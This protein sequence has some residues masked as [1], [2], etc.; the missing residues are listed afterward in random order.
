MKY[1]LIMSAVYYAC[2]CFYM[3]FGPYAIVSNIKSSTNRLFMLLTSSMA[4]WAFTYSIS[5]SAM[6]A[7]SSAF[8]RCLSVFGWGIFHN[9]LLHFALILTNNKHQV[10]NFKNFIIV[11][12]PTFINIFL[13]AP[14][15]YL[16]ENQYEM[17]PSDFGW[18]NSLPANIGQIWINFYYIVYTVAA[19]ILIIRWWKKLDP[20]NPMK[21]QVQYFLIAIMLPLVVGTIN[22]I[23][24]GALGLYQTPRITLILLIFPTI[25]LFQTLKKFGFIIEKP[26]ATYSPMGST[27]ALEKGR[28]R[29]FQ[30]AAVIFMA[31]G[32][33]SF[34][35]GYFTAS[36]SLANELPLALTVIVIGAFLIFIPYISAKDN[37]Q[38]TL[39]L[40]VSIV[41]MSFFIIRDADIGGVTIWAVYVVFLLYTIILNSRIH[42]LLFLGITLISQVI[43]WITHPKAYTV[44][45]DT[46]YLKRIVIVVLSYVLVRYLTTEYDSKLKGYQRFAKEHEVLEK[47][48]SSFI[49]VDNENIKAKI[50]GMLK[51]T[52]EIL[53]IDQIYLVELGWD[54]EY[55]MIIDAYTADGSTKSLPFPPGVKVEAAA[56]P[57]VE[58]MIEHKQPISCE[59]I[60][61]VFVDE[62]GDEGKFFTSRGINSYYMLP[63]ELDENII[64]VLVVEQ[65][66]KIDEKLR[67]SQAYFLSLIANI[68]GD[69]KRKILDEEKLYNF[70]YFDEDT[71]LANK[72]RL[73][74]VLDQ[75][76]YSR[77]DSGKLAVLSIEIDNLR[78]IKDTFGHSIGEQ[79]VIKSATMIENLLEECCDISRSSEGEFAIVLPTVEDTKQVENCAQTLIDSFSHPVVADTGV[80]ALFA[81]IH[82]GISV[83]PDDGK[84][85][86]TLLKNADMAGFQA[87]NTSKDI[88]FYSKKLEEH[89]AENT[90]FTNR[91][92]RSLQNKEFFLEFQPQVSCDT[93]KTVGAEALLRWTIDGNKRVS[94]DRFIS[95]LEQ[96]GLIYDVGLWVF[97]QT[98]QEHKRLILRGFP[99]LRFSVNLSIVQLQVE[100]LILDFAEIIGRNRVDPKYIELE[101]TES[102][103][104]EHPEDVIEKLS[105]LK[106]LG[107]GIALDD[108]GKGYSSLHRLESIPFDRIKI[109]KSI[110]DDIYLKEKKAAIVE[111]IISLARTLMADITAEGV[112]TKEQVDFLRN[113]A[114]DEIQGYYFSRPLLPEALEEFLDK[115]AY[116]SPN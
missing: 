48:S 65:Y 44:I 15:G 53:K 79:I 83:Y 34:F 91:L 101:I 100:D 84:D 75:R 90:L 110:I 67:E 56:F 37:I 97:E 85:A 103:F 33:G 64:G 35:L 5:N 46:Q 36:G 16:A 28:L 107:V 17:V 13:F 95:I 86:Y 32:A 51:S 1:S 2:A 23:L 72:N 116:R 70:A 6:T 105:S 43:L 80:E 50:S 39:F 54:Y 99:P 108:F 62:D 66:S 21:R 96:T 92:F 29:L 25:V 106:E 104:S 49:S 111:T 58:S 94:P 24:P 112:E 7:E 19:V 114:C 47:I 87:K 18:R 82:I 3:L 4:I 88:V 93:G 81:V 57:T 102:V 69:A 40:V 31:G 61:N 41:G 76:I 89:I 45:D 20:Q 59:D 12:F 68:L 42:T 38:N 63:I 73:I 10:N 77:R 109:D 71:K 8:W 9:L 55:A 27:I 52:A 11:Y 26:R 98:L 22:D 113:I 78:I 30:T 14:F 115:E 60:K 74:Q